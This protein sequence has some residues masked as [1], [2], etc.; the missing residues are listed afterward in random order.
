M[1]PRLVLLAALFFAGCAHYPVNS[2][3][4]QFDPH[5]GYRFANFPPTADNTDDLFIVLALSGGGARAAAFSYGILEQLEQTKIRYA[6]KERSL[7]DEVDVITSVSGSSFTAAYY[8]LHHEKT[9]E[10]FPRRYLYGTLE[11]HLWLNAANP[12]NW[13]R[14]ASPTFDRIDLAAETY[15]SDIFDK[16]TYAD[17]VKARRRPYLIMSAADMTLG[18]R[19]EFTQEQ[20]DFLYSDL[21]SVPLARAVAASAAFPVFLSPV[22][23]ANQRHESDFAEPAWIAAAIA[24]EKESP[25]IARR[26]RDLRSYEDAAARPRVRLLDGAIADYMGLRGPMESFLSDA[27]D[28]SLRRLLAGGKIKKLVILSIN[29]VRTPNPDWDKNAF[30][31]G[32][33]DVLYY[34]AATP[35]RNN[36][37]DTVTVFKD[38][39][40]ADAKAAPAGAARYETHFIPIDFRGIPDEALRGR[41]E[42]IESSLSLKRSQADDLRRGAEAALKASPEFNK[43]LQTLQ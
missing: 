17:L 22:T 28:F 39:L 2:R 24:G 25:R 41:L 34:T 19:F 43:M 33:Y 16:A 23:L 13:P 35:I 3:L 31:P 4:Q 32:W 6:G 40:E 1:L 21:G 8:A 14:L 18:S 29:A 5:G 15:D 38:M 42:A 9:F 36:S 7:L 26:A 37:F 12:V 30:A 20:F 27:P 10:E 11:S